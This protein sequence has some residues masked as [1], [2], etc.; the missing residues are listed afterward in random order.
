MGFDCPSRCNE[1]TGASFQST[2]AVTSPTLIVWLDFVHSDV[3]FRVP[4]SLVGRP[5]LG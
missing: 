1:T 4:K 5:V 2:V 3:G